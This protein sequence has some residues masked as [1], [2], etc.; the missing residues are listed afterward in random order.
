VTP[1]SLLFPLARRFVAGESIDDAIATVRALNATGMRATIDLLGEDV[2]DAASA[3]RTRDGYLAA[4]DRIAAA[5]VETNLSIKLSALG[6]TFDRAGALSRLI[7]VMVGAEVL[8]D[9][10][11]RVD[12]EGS[13][14]VDDT[15]AV[16][17]AAFDQLPTTGPALQAALHRTP[18]DVADAIDR[19][20]RVRLCKGAYREPSEIALHESEPIR[21]RF[22]ALAMQLLERGSYPA[23][24]THDPLLIGAIRQVAR[25][26]AIAPDRFEFQLLY[27]VRPD[28][29]AALVAD[30]WRVRVYV[31]FGTHWA[32]Y[33]RRR[34]SERREN[35][36][37]ALRSI[38]GR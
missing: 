7:D 22:L 6:L 33:M 9:P 2:R 21:V 24:A 3:D 28:L 12:M 27:G 31:P 36:V 17:R 30:G 4:I 25:E 15:L 13:A 18:V 26:R 23:F 14:L 38:A 32:R 37:F 11:V 34:V 10:F 1:Q 5:G 16:V 35:L 29:Q 8:A 20:M 19:A